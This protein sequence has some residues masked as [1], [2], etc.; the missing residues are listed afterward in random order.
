[1]RSDRPYSYSIPAELE[2]RLVPGMRVMIPFGAGNR[3]C[4][5]IVLAVAERADER[6]LKPI[7]ALLDD[8][9]VLDQEGRPACP[10]GAGAVV[11]HGLRG[12]AGH[13]AAGLWFSLQDT[14]RVSE[15][16]DKE[17]AYDAAGRSA[18]AHSL[19]DILYANGGAVEIGCLRDALGAGIRTPL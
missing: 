4:D 7:L 6:Q 3:R 15:G 5:G 14:W 2:D 13:A 18:I 8:E 16:V 1:M 17:K 11:L 10:L 12:G 9:P 19:L